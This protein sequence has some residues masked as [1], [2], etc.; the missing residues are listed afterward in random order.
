[1]N[2][3]QSRVLLKK[4]KVHKTSYSETAKKKGSKHSFILGFMFRTNTL[5]KS[6]N[7]LILQA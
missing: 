5:G 3:W 4:V 6:I 1:M 7:H 2:E